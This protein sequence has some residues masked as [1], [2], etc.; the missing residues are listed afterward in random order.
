MPVGQVY[1]PHV[2]VDAVHPSL[3]ALD[4]LARERLADPEARRRV[5][6]AEGHIDEIRAKH[7]LVVFVHDLQIDATGEA[8]LEQEGGLQAGDSAPRTTT[9]GGGELMSSASAQPG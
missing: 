3:P 2:G 6:G 8:R 9:R 4:R 1:A 5:I 7:E